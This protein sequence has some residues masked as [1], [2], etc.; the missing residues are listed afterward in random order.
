[1]YLLDKTIK[2][3]PACDVNT[4]EPAQEQ[5]MFVLVHQVRL[6]FWSLYLMCSTNLNLFIIE[7]DCFLRRLGLKC[8]IHMDLFYIK[9][10]A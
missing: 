3:V 2:F 5:A 6:N 7:S 4:F 8:P 10:I 9:N 1:M